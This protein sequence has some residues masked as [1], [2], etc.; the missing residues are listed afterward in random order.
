MEYQMLDRS[1]LHCVV[2]EAPSIA[3][4]SILCRWRHT[5]CKGATLSNITWAQQSQTS[6][7]FFHISL[8]KPTT[9]PSCAKL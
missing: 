8:Q 3:A 4:H 1:T 6:V 2:C 9:A 5:Y 7:Y